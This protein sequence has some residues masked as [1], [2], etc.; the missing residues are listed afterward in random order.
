MK[1]GLYS[2]S[3]NGYNSYIYQVQIAYIHFTFYVDISTYLYIG[4][5]NL[6]LSK[7]N[8]YVNE[9]ALLQAQVQ[10]QQVQP[11][12]PAAPVTQNRTQPVKVVNKKRQSFSYKLKQEVIK[13]Y[14][15]EFLAC[16]CAAMTNTVVYFVLNNVQ[17]HNVQ[18]FL[19]K[20][21]LQANGEKILEL[22]RIRTRKSKFPKI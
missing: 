2:F 7:Q 8:L 12:S 13:H 11:A 21:Y 6:Q 18:N 5:P 15:I 17:E 3:D 14:K 19:R 22:E 1:Y 9:T 4:K 10:N 16:P 20:E